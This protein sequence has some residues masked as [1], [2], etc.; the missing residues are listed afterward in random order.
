MSSATTQRPAEPLDE[1]RRLQAR[2]GVEVA[3]R[4]QDQPGLDAGRR[5]ARSTAAFT[6]ST[7]SAGVEVAVGVQVRREPDLGV[8]DA[9]A[10]ELV[11]QVVDDHLEAAPVLHQRHDPRR[12]QQEVG[13]VGALGGR[14]EVGPVLL[15]RHLGPQPRDRGVAGGAVEVQVQLDL[16]Q[17]G[18]RGI[19]VGRYFGPMP[20]RQHLIFDA[21]DTLWENNVVF[22]GVIAD[23]IAWIDHPSLAGPRCGPSSTRSSACTRSSTATAPRCSRSRSR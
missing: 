20:A 6:I 16:G 13:Q 1:L 22:E 10:G 18:H 8:D 21:D 4:A 12:A 2:G 23:F 9:V 15:E 3:Q 5:D 19:V 7:T 11:E 14:D 17:R